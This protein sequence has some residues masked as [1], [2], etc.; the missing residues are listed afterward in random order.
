MPLEVCVTQ[1][2]S[3]N[4]HTPQ[5]MGRRAWKTKS[6]QTR[7]NLGMTPDAMPWD[8]RRPKP[9]Y[10]GLPDSERMRDLLNVAWGSRRP[11][12]RS[13]RFYAD[14]SQ[15]VS[16]KVWG[17]MVPCVTTSSCI[18]SYE[19]DR[20]LTAHDLFMLFGL[21]ADALTLSDFR[22]EQLRALIG[23]AMFAPNIGTLLLAT[24]LQADAPWWNTS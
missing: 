17:T 23:E 3:Q 11:K 5:V 15:C 19:Q 21:P 20:R 2:H 14:C 22:E 4:E 1:T 10:G 8:M 7:S 9:T 12:E 6:L 13:A 16:W 24:F 18:Y